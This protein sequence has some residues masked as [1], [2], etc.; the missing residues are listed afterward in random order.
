MHGTACETALHFF[1]LKSFKKITLNSRKTKQELLQAGFPL[2][3]PQT[4]LAASGKTKTFY[5]RLM[6]KW[7]KHL[8]KIR[9]QAA[10]AEEDFDSY[11]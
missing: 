4:D 2:Q 9:L 6:A 3:A 1:P 7:L 10:S 11:S 8:K 5:V